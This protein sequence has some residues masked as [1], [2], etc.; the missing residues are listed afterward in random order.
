MAGYGFV[1]LAAALWALIGPLARFCLAEG[2]TP[3]EIAMWRA[4]FGTLFFGLHALRSGLWR[5]EPAHAAG[6][7]AFGIVGVGVFFGAYQYAVREGG[8]ALASVL[9]YTAPAWVALLSRLV[10]R[11]PLSRRKLLALAVAMAGAALTCLS[12]GGLPGGTSTA[13]IFAG[14]LAGFTYSLHYIFSAHWMPRYSP[15]TLYLYCLPAG[16]LALMPFTALAPKSLTTW[17]LLVALGLLTTYCAY[18]AYCEGVRR[19][20]PTRA[21]VVANMEPVLAALLAFWWWGEIFPPAGWAGAALVLT[22]VFLIVIDKGGT[23][24]QPA[25]TEGART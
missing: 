19:L 11:E 17:G 23:V 3:L 12:G 15:V 6:F 2:V 5:A 7:T 24:R 16:A 9:L 1:L 13:G 4:W 25:P 10:L 18:L 22:A 14:L 21:A 8:A 20:A